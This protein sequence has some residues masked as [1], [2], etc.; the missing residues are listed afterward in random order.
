MGKKSHVILINPPSL[1]VEDD[2][3]E[4]P[5]GLLYIAA[6]L[7]EQNRATVE[8]YDMSGS[9]TEKE[10]ANR[11]NNI[12]FADIYGITGMCT[13]FQYIDSITK[14]IR[15]RSPEA[16]IVTGGPNATAIPQ[17]TFSSLD[18]DVV[19]A[20]EG[21]DA[22][23]ELVKAYQ[24]G[25]PITGIVKGVPK[26]NIDNYQNPDRDLVDM[27]DY[28][29]KLLGFPSVSMLSSR[30]CAYRCI[31]CNSVLMGGGSSGVRYRSISSILSEIESLTSMGY[32]HIRFNDDHFTGNPDL[33]DL[34][35]AFIPLGIKFR[36]FARVGDLTEKNCRLLKQAGCVHVT[37]G[38][39]SMNRQNL[40]A[41]GKGAQAGSEMN[42]RIAIDN[43]LTVRASFIVGLPF[44]SDNT[45][46][47][48]FSIAGQ[49][50][51]SEYELYSLIPYPGTVLWEKPE[52][53]GYTIESRD[54][55]RYIQMG[56]SGKT[57][58]VLRHKNFT[59]GDVS[60]W[61]KRAQSILESA[62]IKHMKNSRIA[63]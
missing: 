23:C 48:D 41:L 59:P 9:K 14:W 2:R 60:R 43:G 21:E 37:V 31:H 11:I 30:G 28:S 32:R 8:I 34:L 63:T 16:Y 54:F 22:M 38:L 39:E 45:I 19:V 58:Y 15:S 40:I 53:L 44:D 25:T 3:L 35:R 20:G 51:L 10:I 50:G 4:P 7:K 57:C 29:R 61:R 18:V 6:A 27:S 13:H 1:S 49:L 47:R 12:P 26:A 56:K 42:T 5:L 24:K 17:E 55:K 52:T 36:I 33:E 46:E 62:G